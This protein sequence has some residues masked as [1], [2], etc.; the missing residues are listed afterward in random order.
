MSPANLVRFTLQGDASF[1][2]VVTASSTAG[3]HSL[4]G[5]L[6]D[7]DRND[8]TVGGATSVTVR[9]PA[10]ATPTTPPTL[11]PSTPPRRRSRG[12]G[13]GGGIAAPRA[14]T[15]AAG[16]TVRS[17]AP[18]ETA[19]AQA[20]VKT[21]NAG[22]VLITIAPEQ[23]T[24]LLQ[25]FNAVGTVFDITAPQ[26]SVEEPLVLF[27]LVRTQ[28]ASGDLIVL[29]DGVTVGNCRG[30]SGQ[31][32]PDPCVASQGKAG[33]TVV[34]KV[35]TSEA[36]IW[37]FRSLRQAVPTPAPTMAPTPD[38]TVVVVLPRP[39]A[40]PIAV[41]KPVPTAAPTARPTPEPSPTA[42]PEPTVMAPQLLRLPQR[43]KGYPLEP[44]KM[45]KTNKY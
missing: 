35:L 23:A 45:T 38:P 36:G 8:Y 15:V 19:P 28:T 4:S 2:Y 30:A 33:T 14:G 44:N 9:A 11:A 3:S 22:V 42:A 18:S 27:F 37:E 16:A 41:P 7:F 6:R 13:G 1:T 40:T 29:K 32:S 26:A 31:A 5:T 43:P 21:P 20:S 25:G 17:P 24:P 34:T 10:V 39:T 12:G